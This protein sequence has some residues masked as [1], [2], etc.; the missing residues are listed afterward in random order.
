MCEIF[1]LISVDFPCVHAGLW[2]RN[3]SQRFFSRVRAYLRR[4]IVEFKNLFWF[5]SGCIEISIIHEKNLIYNVHWIFNIKSSIFPYLSQLSCVACTPII[6]FFRILVKYVTWRA[7][8]LLFFPHFSQI[9]CVA[10][11]AIPLSFR[12]LVKYFA[13]VVHANYSLFRILDRYSAWA[14]TPIPLFFRILD[15]YLAWACTSR[16]ARYFFSAF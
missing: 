7:R 12:I 6:L 8:Q 15:R 5:V 14:C 3:Q 2:S 13:L 1:W 11:M 16:H 10:C 9:S 4:M